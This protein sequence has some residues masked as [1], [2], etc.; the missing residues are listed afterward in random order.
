MAGPSSQPALLRASNI[1]KRFGITQAL[2]DVSV[3]FLKGEVHALMG[4]NGAGK[5][6]L[7]KVIAGLHKQDQ[8]TVVIDGRELVPGSLDD[9]FAAGVRIVHQELAQCPNLT[10]A[11]NLCLHAIPTRGLRVDFRAMV[12]RAARLVHRLEPTID[13]LRPLGRLSPGHRQICQIAA[14]LDEEGPHG[15]AKL[16]VFDEPTSSLSIHETERLLAI[17]RDL[18]ASGVTVVYVSHRMSEI[19]ACCD[20]VSVLRDGKYVATSVVAEID[21]PTLVEQMIGRRLATPGAKAAEALADAAGVDHQVR[22]D[23]PVL[24][25]VEGLTSPGRVNNASLQVRAGEIVGVGGLVGAGRSELLDAI[26]GLDTRA[27]GRVEVAGRNIG[28]RGPRA[29]IRAGVGYVPEDRRQQGLFFNLGIDEN[30]LA[31]IMPDLARAGVRDRTAEIDEVRSRV[32]RF[33]IKTATLRTTGPGEL[34][35][36]NQQ[37]L[38]IA[39]WMRDDTKVLLLDEPTRGIDIGTKAEIYRLVQE[40]A[41]AGLAV[42]LVSSEMPEL[43]ALSDR[44]LVMAEGRIGGELSGQ[45]MTQKNI[46]TLATRESRKKNAPA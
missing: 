25:R 9:A 2:D 7:G 27:S 45:D 41:A 16:I 15:G 43:L 31:P 3:E 18:A 36:G 14:A 34:S 42:L 13:I 17:A 40:A 32:Q 33:Q 30:I 24:L 44:I 26:F 6:T 1:S 8:G 10:V 21:E 12:E 5:S 28:G 38:L 46:L 11:E 20:R 22:A 4:E 37:K 23:A 19:F 39:R 29:A 35:G